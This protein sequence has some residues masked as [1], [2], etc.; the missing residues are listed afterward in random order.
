METDGDFVVL[1]KDKQEEAIGF[2]FV[3]LLLL[4]LKHK[5]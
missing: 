2:F 1:S 3:L 5:I 4:L